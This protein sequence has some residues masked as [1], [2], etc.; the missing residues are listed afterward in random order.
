M[1]N[2]RVYVKFVLFPEKIFFFKI[3]IATSC[4]EKNRTN[5]DE[6]DFVKTCANIFG[7]EA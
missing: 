7:L 5:F 4:A 3:V 1:A 2:K 6:C